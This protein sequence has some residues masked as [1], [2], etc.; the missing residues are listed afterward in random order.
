VG[1]IQKIKE[2]DVTVFVGEQR[3]RGRFSDDEEIR[4]LSPAVSW[5]E[6]PLARPKGLRGNPDDSGEK[7][8]RDWP[9][10]TSAAFDERG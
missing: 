8:N 4:R 1:I 2:A 7:Q 6:G 5:N 10:I 9:R 3:P